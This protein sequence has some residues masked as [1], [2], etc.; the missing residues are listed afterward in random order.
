MP[1]YT[2]E[3]IT[4]SLSE[5]EILEKAKNEILE[6]NYREFFNKMDKKYPVI[7][8]L[9][10]GNEIYEIRGGTNRMSHRDFINL[11]NTEWGKTTYAKRIKTIET[12]IDLHSSKININNIGYDFVNTFPVN[13]R[14]NVIYTLSKWNNVKRM[15]DNCTC[16]MTYLKKN[17]V[18]DVTPM[19]DVV[20]PMNDVVIPMN[21]VVIPKCIVLNDDDYEGWD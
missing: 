18:L 7:K 10:Y 8:P 21:D 13:E 9:G 12:Q 17:F 16:F 19:K 14:P 15:Y 3:E 5:I 11:V 4:K 2:E 6:N 20:T 1:F